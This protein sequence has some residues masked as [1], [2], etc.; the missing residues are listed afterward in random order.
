MKLPRRE[1]GMKEVTQRVAWGVV[2]GTVGAM[3]MT[4]MRQVT[5]GLG[6][7][8]QTPPDAIIKQRASGLLVRTP[9]LAFLVAKRQ[10]AV[11]ELAHWF[12][13][14][15]GGAA[16]AMLPHRVLRSRWVGPG[17]GVLTTAMFELGIVP[18]LGLDKAKKIRPAE[19]LMFLA[20]HLLYGIILA[21]GRKWALPKKKRLLP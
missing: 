16:F 19:Q 8:E 10:T 13:G 2:R 1:A 11:I 9:R 6:L 14:A 18:I 12:Y 17:Y 20:D 7:V 4:G 15:A 5:T 21:G 3:A